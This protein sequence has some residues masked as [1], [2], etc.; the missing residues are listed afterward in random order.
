MKL[1]LKPEA[2]IKKKRENAD[3]IESN[4]RLRQMYKESADRIRTAK[5]D[6]GADKLRAL[7][8]F[9]KFCNSIN[10]KKSKLLQEYNGILKAIEN[11][12]EVYYGL[13]AKQDE[14]EEREFKVIEREKKVDLREK[15]I[16]ELEKKWTAKTK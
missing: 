1:L 15:F 16:S 11:K 12:K 4:I 7:D 2:E 14:L 13:V 6:Y 9:E 10:D 3:L 5:I 8:E